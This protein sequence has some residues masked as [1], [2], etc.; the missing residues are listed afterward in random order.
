MN[1]TPDPKM[2]S[3][4]SVPGALWAIRDVL[5]IHRYLAHGRPHLRVKTKNLGIPKAAYVSWSSCASSHYH[6]TRTCSLRIRRTSQHCTHLVS[7]IIN[8][9]KC[10]LCVVLLSPGP[11]RSHAMPR[12][13]WVVQLGIGASLLE[14]ERCLLV[15]KRLQPVKV[16]LL[17]H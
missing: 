2:H 6:Q 13:R 14:P 17:W 3:D 10:R 9:C 5:W 7:D 4:S 11:R 12:G 15:K 16:K 8:T 1:G